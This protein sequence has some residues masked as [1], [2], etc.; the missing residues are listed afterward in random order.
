[1]KVYFR[2]D[3][4]KHIGSGHVMRCLSLAESLKAK[5][6]E[7]HFV[8]RPQEGDLCDYTDSRG[9][10]VKRLPKIVEPKLPNNTA[11]YE[12]WLQVSLIDDA[13]D[14]LL[15]A[16]DAELIIIDHYGISLEWEKY[17]KSF[18]KC[19]QFAI[20]DLVRAHCADLI[21][22][23]TYDKKAEE[24]LRISPFS[25]VL[26]GSKYALLNP[27]FSE[28]HMASIN[29]SPRIENHKLL[30]TMGGVD[31]M[32]VT[33][34]VLSA[35]SRRAPKFQTTVLLNEKAPHYSSVASFCEKHNTWV[36]HVP[37]SEDMAGL[38]AE[39]TI[40]IG[41]PG[42]TSWERACIGLPSI[43]I[44]LAENQREICKSLVVADAS[45]S[46]EIAEISEFLNNKLDDLLKRY[47]IMRRRALNLCDG[48]GV[49]RLV[50]KL[51]LIGWI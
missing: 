19:K 7:I 14:F 39:H 47:S 3:A 43:L 22:D 17:V 45:I 24:Y 27:K 38:M 37:F 1:M 23:Q 48:R 35:L 34:K 41:A 13:Q 33:L 42:S 20:D 2:V 21:L 15:A 9:F 16:P 25:E 32:N 49:E 44:P 30:I 8:M 31:N 36:K 40:S 18:I 26:V 28:L 6:H 4:S 11:D 51:S 29:K 10:I 50:E 12:A 5:G 46:L